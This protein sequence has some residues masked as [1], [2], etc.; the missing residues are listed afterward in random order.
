MRV[1]HPEYIH[2]IALQFA[3]VD[4]SRSVMARHMEPAIRL[5][6][7]EWQAVRVLMQEW[8]KGTFSIIEDRIKAVL[9][10]Y[11]PTPR[12]SLQMR[13]KD[14]RWSSVEFGQ[15]FRAMKENRTLHEAPDGTVTLPG[16]SGHGR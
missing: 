9:R 4:G 5:L 15:V 16:R 8:G 14:R 1:R 13:C 3:V 2:K 11:G 7:W 6:D 10:K 12:R